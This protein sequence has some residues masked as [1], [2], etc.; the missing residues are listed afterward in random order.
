MTTIAY[1]DGVIA[2]DSRISDGA[3]IVHDDYD[4][5]QEVK[6]VQ[7]VFTGK[8]CDYAKLVG[9]WFGEPVSVEL[10][11]AAMVFDG[12]GLWYAGAS[13]EH[14]LCKTPIWLDR[15]YVM[16]SGGDHAATAMD[17]GASAAEAV[18][19]AKKRDSSSGG[20]VRTLKLQGTQ[21]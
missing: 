2:Y 12:E 7:F 19:M 20:V 5:R 10:D 4:K 16:G 18:E 3:F 11:C 9:A 21:A 1:K 8:V 6:G 14:G 15:S 13:P 17:M